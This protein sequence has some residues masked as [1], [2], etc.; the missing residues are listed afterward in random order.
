[1]QAKV[2]IGIANVDGQKH[3]DERAER[4]QGAEQR[5][6]DK[7]R[8]GRGYLVNTTGDIMPHFVCKEDAHHARRERP[9][10]EDIAKEHKYRAIL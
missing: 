7:K 6:R 3:G 9:A 4:A 5:S 2:D 1:M 10:S 8:Q